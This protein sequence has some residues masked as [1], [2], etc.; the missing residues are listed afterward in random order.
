MLNL[1]GKYGT[2]NIKGQSIDVEKTAIVKL[3]EYIKELKQKRNQLIEEQ[4]VYISQMIP[5]RSF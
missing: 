2:A 5:K 1:Y 4:N 3:E